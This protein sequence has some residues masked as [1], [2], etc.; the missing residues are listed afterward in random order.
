MIVVR[1]KSRE[2]EQFVRRVR[3]RFVV[4][5]VVERVGLGILFACAAA[6]PLLLI[7]LWLGQP[8]APLAPAALLVGAL[9]GGVWGILTR[10]TPL[11]AAMEADRQLGWADLLGS[12]LSVGDRSDDP[13][14]RAVALAADERCRGAAARA[15]ILNR[16]G[17]RAWGG[18]GLAGALVLILGL[19]PTYSTLTQAQEGSHAPGSDMLS[20]HAD[21]QA[22]RFS[23]RAP[24]RTAIQ[25]EPEDA[26]RDRVGEEPTADDSSKANQQ[27][28]SQAAKPH[29]STGA[30]NSRGAGSSHTNVKDPGAL[31]QAQQN[32][33]SA[34][35]NPQGAARDGSGRGSAF[36]SD[37]TGENSGTASQ[38]SSAPAP[39]AWQSAEW[40]ADV[41]RAHQAIESGQI[42]DAYRDVVRG[43]F[44]RQ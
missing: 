18:I 27:P 25:A 5:R 1:Q 38:E 31:A 10:P 41:N 44:D 22:S 4:L 26:G 14:A 29:D 19:M 20:M 39:P 8:A 16:L 21:Q 36:P 43:Y 11:E 13:W 30:S 33:G 9:G 35:A 37:A 34:S 28:S 42:P 40:P 3:R 12:A 32:T 17:A 15:V 23:T 2:F 7:A 24:R 6:I